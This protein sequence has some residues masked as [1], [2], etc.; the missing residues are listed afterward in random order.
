MRRTRWCSALASSP[1]ARRCSSRSPEEIRSR[2]GWTRS[3][4]RSP[5]GAETHPPAST[6]P[7]RWGS[8]TRLATAVRVARG[9]ML[10]PYEVLSVVGAGGMAE[11]YRAR[12]GRLGREIA[13]KVVNE[14]LAASPDL[15][16]RFEQEARIAGALNHP[17]IVAVYDVGVH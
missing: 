4:P 12:D 1:R 5:A 9:H 2:C 10:G 7:P 13:L 8:C 11:V 16:K 15:V 17:N 3:R 14:T 6:W